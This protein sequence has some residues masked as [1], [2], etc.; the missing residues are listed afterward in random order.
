[1]KNGLTG[2]FLDPPYSAEEQ[3]TAHL[4]SMDDLVVAHRVRDWCAA[5]GADPGLRII[6]C[7][8]GEAHD[9]LLAQGWTKYRWHAQGGYAGHGHS[10]A[11]VN[12]WREALWASPACLHP[13]RGQLTL[14]DDATKDQQGKEICYETDPPAFS[15][16]DG[17]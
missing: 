3:R 5:Q 10:R 14:F 4:Y 17:L 1:V 13:A 11:R 9:I 2:V 6:L 12:A 15:Q 16:P 8:Y 7:G